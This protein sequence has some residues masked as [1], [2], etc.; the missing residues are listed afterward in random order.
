MM[1]PV[2]LRVSVSPPPVLAV[3]GASVGVSSQDTEPK[4]TECGPH[5]NVANEN[6]PC[7]DPSAPPNSAVGFAAGEDTPPYYV[8]YN[9]TSHCEDPQPWG[10]PANGGEATCA[11]TDFL[12]LGVSAY[13]DTDNWSFA[14]PGISGELGTSV[15]GAAA[16]H[17]RVYAHI[18]Q[19]L[20]T[21]PRLFPLYADYSQAIFKQLGIAALGSSPAAGFADDRAWTAFAASNDGNPAKADPNGIDEAIACV[22]GWD[23]TIQSGYPPGTYV[24]PGAYPLHPE[25]SCPAGVT[26]P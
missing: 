4:W 8:G 23:Q 15:F 14:N 12:A 20:A 16:F 25:Q 6:V 19:F 3:A 5:Y 26:I 13:L 17:Q 10:D 9:L 18:A 1:Q 11:K 7:G 21:Y 22:Y 2:R 24:E